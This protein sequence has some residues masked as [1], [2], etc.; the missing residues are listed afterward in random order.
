MQLKNLTKYT[1]NRSTKYMSKE[2]QLDWQ[3]TSEQQQWKTKE[4]G[5]ISCYN[6]VSV[7]YCWETNHLETDWLKTT[8]VIYCT[9]EFV[10]WVRYG[11]NVSCLSP[12][13]SNKL[14][15]LGTGRFTRSM[16]H[17]HGRQVLMWASPQATRDS[18]QNGGWFPK[19]STP[20][21]QTGSIQHFYDLTWKA[22]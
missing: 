8:M 11:R 13:A 12:E 10:T 17:S 1:L 2:H 5:M 20:R 9:Q 14:C 21:E 4:S 6:W 3:M 15:Q 7:L 19:A 18:L 16:A 22:T